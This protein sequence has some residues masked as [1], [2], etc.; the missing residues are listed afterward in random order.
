MSSKSCPPKF[1]ETPNGFLALMGMGVLVLASFVF[2]PDPFGV[3]RSARR[4]EQLFGS[5]LGTPVATMSV[6][7]N[8]PEV[9]YEQSDTA[10]V[11]VSLDTGGRAVYGVDVLLDHGANFNATGVA[12]LGASG[13]DAFAPVV[14]AVNGNYTFNNAAAIKPADHQ[15]EF[16]VMNFDYSAEEPY[17]A[18]FSGTANLASVSLQPSWVRSNTDV[19]VSLQ[20]QAGNTTDSNVV[21]T[22]L[23]DAL[24]SVNNTTIKIIAAEVCR[25]AYLNTAS[26]PLVGLEELMDLLSHY[27]TVYEPANINMDGS[28]LIDLQDLMILLSYYGQA[29]VAP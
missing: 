26:D 16:G 18:P 7:S 2:H 21:D 24:A 9:W 15:V 1:W 10:T 14:D 29:C 8:T 5:V 3:K 25:A 23:D 11:T 4:P 19:N 20:H 6:S 27:G 13:L 22:D 28:N 12:P 17:S